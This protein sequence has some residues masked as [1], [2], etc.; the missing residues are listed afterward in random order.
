MSEPRLALYTFGQFIQASQHPSNQGFHD[1]NDA[2]LAAV[3]RA[4]GLIGR[5]GYDEEPGPQ[6][7]GPQVYPRFFKDAHGDGWAPSTLSLWQGLDAIWAY[8][9]G[10][11][12]AE[13]LTKARAWFQKGDWP[14]LVLW[15]TDQRPDWAEGVRRL[16]HLHDH[17]PSRLAFGFRQAFDAAGAPLEVNRAR[18][19]EMAALNA[20]PA[21]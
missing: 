11:I 3:D 21:G 14:P 16:E 13:A 17:G 8:T 12:H 6:S 1:R 15:W 5:S 19:R 2:N 9:Y 4:H 20:R 18:V 10:G 7:W